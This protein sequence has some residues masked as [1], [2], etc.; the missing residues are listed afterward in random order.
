MRI[1]AK[2][3]SS[4][5]NGPGKRAVVWFQGCIGM[6]CKS[7]CWN[8]ET[9][10]TEKGYG[11]SPSFIAGWISG[12]VESLGLDGVTFSG[13]EP[14]QQANDLVETIT[15]LKSLNPTISIGMFSG[16]TEKELEAGKYPALP[17][18]DQGTSEQ[19]WKRI[20]GSL[21]FAVLGRYNS[22]LPERS[23]PLVT[24]S[25]QKLCL[26]SD[27]YQFSDFRPLEVEVFIDNK[28]TVQITGFP[29][30]GMLAMPDC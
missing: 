17:D 27:R 5:V 10:D 8:P 29:V 28:G 2:L 9:H 6:S 23:K 12:C 30:N 16:Y 20:K 7:T 21:D 19:L 25:N 24:S 22:L 18:R 26:F 4:T 1:H 14:M 13:G 11:Y 15:I 3:V